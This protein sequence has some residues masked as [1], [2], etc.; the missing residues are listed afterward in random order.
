MNPL[1]FELS[2]AAEN[3]LRDIIRYTNQKFG[4]NQAINYGNQLEACMIELSTNTPFPRNLTEIQPNLK[5]IRCQH[6]YIFGIN[7]SSQPFLVIPILH[8][9]MDVLNRIK[10][11]L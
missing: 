4:Q 3:D 7:R 1:L 8:E 9:K 11:R 5:F 10:K 6:H 2:P